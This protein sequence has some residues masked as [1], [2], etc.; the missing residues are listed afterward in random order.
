MPTR[1]R[2]TDYDADARARFQWMNRKAQR[3]MSYLLR[4]AAYLKEVE[5]SGESN[6]W[7]R[8]EI[9]SLEF[10]FGLLEKE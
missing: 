3:H 2:I 4:R 6:D 9:S 10:V 5:E 8:A 1:R 7:D